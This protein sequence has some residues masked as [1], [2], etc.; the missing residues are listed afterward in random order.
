MTASTP[1]P[2]THGF[3]LSGW[4]LVILAGGALAAGAFWREGSPLGWIIATVVGHFFLF[5][6][7]FL[8]WRNLELL[9][10]LAF[11]VN[12][13]AHLTLGSAS[14]LSVLLFQLPVSVAVIVWQI[15]S[16]W[17]HGIAARRWN[18][19]LDDYLNGKL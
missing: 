15:R 14:A 5:C 4:D 12:A 19:R 6:N 2:R 7:I 18:P 10:A 13:A 1:P 11:V 9:W 16:P 17:Y 3:R 8:V